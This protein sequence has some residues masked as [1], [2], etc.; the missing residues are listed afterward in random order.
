MEV[1]NSATPFVADS[2]LLDFTKPTY[3]FRP[4]SIR[5]A[6]Q[7][8]KNQFS[9][10]ILYAVKTNPR[11]EVLSELVSNGTDAFDVASLHECALIK[12]HF[13]HCALF[14]MHPVKSR[15]EIRRAYLEYG[16]RHFSLDTL[17]ELKKIQQETDY[18]SDLSLH[19]RLATP[20]PYAEIKLSHKFGANFDSAVELLKACSIVAA[21]T[22]I[23]FHVGSQCMS[24]SA[25]VQAIELAA[26]V[27]RQSKVTL[28]Y[29]N[30]GGGFPV[31]YAH[32]SPP[33]LNE[34]F[35]AIMNA[36]SMIND[37]FELLAE[38]G[39]ALVAESMSLVVRVLLRKEQILY[40][41]DGTYG[42]LFDAGMPGFVFPVRLLN[43]TDSDKPIP[44]S[45]YGPTCDSLDFMPG[46]FYLPETTKEGDYIEIGQLGAYSQSLASA[47][48]GFS[49]EQQL[50][51]TN[52]PP[53]CSIFSD[54]EAFNTA[55]IVNLNEVNNEQRHT[56]L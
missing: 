7:T 2:N 49:H 1:S 20:N 17:D 16:V 5:K 34:Y 42:G 29:F 48:N 52:T 21:E 3:L 8:F 41:N 23:S 6:V 40:I 53:V 33:D 15:P 10:R 46:P 50:F 18:A 11:L 22:G 26:K 54:A 45:F 44:F 27:V 56:A 38:P 39:R 36:Y 31:R 28:S 35:T 14:F 47:F 55:K 19:V 30:V 12:N 43:D 13:P 24:P 25:Y 51:K 4:S 32:L 9:A 37:H